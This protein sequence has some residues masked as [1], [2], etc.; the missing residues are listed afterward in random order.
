MTGPVV[1]VHERLEIAALILLIT[2]VVVGLIALGVVIGS[3]FG[4][5]SLCGTLTYHVVS[6]GP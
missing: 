4:W 1:S 5:W 3:A 6:Q 2:T